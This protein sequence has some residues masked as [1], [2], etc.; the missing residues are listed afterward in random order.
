[1][2][3]YVGEYEQK[4]SVETED[5]ILGYLKLT[6]RTNI[7]DLSTKV[8]ISSTQLIKILSIIRQKREFVFFIDGNEVYMPGYERERPKEVVK[9]IVKEVVKIPC[10]HCG[11]LSDPN[12]EKCPNC[13]APIKA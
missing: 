2:G 6:G 4:K 7:E 5:K 8:G 9:E 12:A 3:N 13:S 11:Y 10:K 1:M